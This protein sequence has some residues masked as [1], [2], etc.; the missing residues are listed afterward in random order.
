MKAGLPVD[1]VEMLV[2]P[3]QS[4]EEEAWELKEV[5]TLEWTYDVARQNPLP[6]YV[7]LE[8][9]RTHPPLSRKEG[10]GKES[11]TS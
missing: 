1:K 6:D 9:Q 5:E 8:A 3:W 11:L 2:L 10:T 4:T 7:S